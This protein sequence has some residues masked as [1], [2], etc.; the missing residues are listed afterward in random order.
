MLLVENQVELVH[1][2]VSY[3]HV[4]IE[5]R[6]EEERERGCHISSEEG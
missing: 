5:M 3:I 6:D 4:H 1:T 2:S